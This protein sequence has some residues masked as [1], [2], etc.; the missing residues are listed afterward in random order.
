MNYTLCLLFFELGTL[1]M[2]LSAGVKDVEVDKWGGYLGLLTAGTAFYLGY[3]EM[4]N[5]IVGKASTLPSGPGGGRGN[6]GG[7][8]CEWWHC[9]DSRAVCTQPTPMPASAFALH[10][11]QPVAPRL[12]DATLTHARAR[13]CPHTFAHPQGKEIVPLFHANKASEGHGGFYVGG[14]TLTPHQVG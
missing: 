14:K 9:V 4:L 7:R 10:L 12:A 2:V 13:A 3:V 11:L 1:F 5:D 8:E 6:A